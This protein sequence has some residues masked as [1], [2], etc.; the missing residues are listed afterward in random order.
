[1]SCPC[2]GTS[3]YSRLIAVSSSTGPLRPSPNV[4]GQLFE[5][6]VLGK[7]E[8]QS[9]RE[10]PFEIADQPAPSRCQL[11]RMETGVP[12]SCMGKRQHDS[13]GHCDGLPGV[14]CGLSLRSPWAGSG[15]NLTSTVSSAGSSGK[16]NRSR[17]RFRLQACL[18][19]L[20]SE[21]AFTVSPPCRVCVRTCI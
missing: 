17:E 21:N 9:A 10:V 14:E 1:M 11:A 18:L 6:R 19:V 3:P 4:P 15:T 8:L 7:L 2:R 5:L 12:N 13:T 20:R 16:I